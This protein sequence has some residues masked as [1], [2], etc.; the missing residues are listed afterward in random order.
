MEIQSNVSDMKEELIALR[1]DLHQHPEVAFQETR[2]SSIAAEQLRSAGFQ[3]ETGIG[4]TG[5]VGT[6]NFGKSGKTLMI[7]ADMD[8][9]PIQEIDGRP[10]GSNTRG[11]M[12]A[13]GHDA[14]TSVALMVARLLSRYK[15]ELRGCLKVVFKP[16]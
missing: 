11:S 12:H 1:R 13:C 8:A 15:D 10:Y 7:R 2:T 3:V 6:L 14:H 9:L 16:A 4:K 5:V